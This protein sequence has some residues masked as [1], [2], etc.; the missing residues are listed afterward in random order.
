MEIN[1]YY[2]PVRTTE[3]AG[4]IQQLPELVREAVPGGA[5]ILI[6]IWSETAALHPVFV[7]LKENCRAARVTI[8]TF[9]ASNPSVRQLF[10]LYQETRKI[11]P[12]LIIAVGG[13]SVMDV[14][15]TLC[16][17]NDIPLSTEEELRDVIIQKR[18]G[19]PGARWIGIPTTA[20]TGSEVTC[21]ATIWD[22]EKNAK[23]SAESR[24][25]YAFAAIVDPE[26][27]AGMPPALAVA[28]ALDAAAHGMESYW[29]KSSNLISRTF[30]LAGIDRIMSHIDR[31][32]AGD[33]KAHEFMAQGSMLTGLAFS[34]TKT[35][36]CHSISYPLTMEYHIPHGAAVSLLMGPVL[37]L[38]FDQIKE[39]EPLLKAL[40]IRTPEEL[41]GRIRSILSSAGLPDT[42]SGWKVPEEA[43]P[44]LASLGMTK[45]RADNNPAVLSAGLV[46]T[47][48]REIYRS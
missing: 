13:G 47:L 31:L 20:G 2:N 42:L 18:Y 30:A 34:N 44:A 39:P 1:H 12:E 10:E 21:W 32:A 37:M 36:A 45:G 24:E 28:S 14:G 23:R 4:S 40:G 29:A 8:R 17:I 35:T 25:N 46:E 16:L 7:S 6:L 26:L 9:Q 22:P 38:N 48:L 3:G 33:I 11:R 19:T 5:N 27:S 41:S 43:L 15:K